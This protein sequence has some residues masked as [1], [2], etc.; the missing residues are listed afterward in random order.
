MTTTTDPSTTVSLA[1]ALAE[2]D[3]ARTVD[4]VADRLR[5]AGIT[6]LRRNTT[7]CPV[8]RYLSKRTGRR[9][10]AGAGQ[11]AT[12]GE[13]YAAYDMPYTVRSF[14]ERFDTEVGSYPDLV[15]TSPTTTVSELGMI[16]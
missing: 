1:E 8:A 12:N 11:V 5:G 14:I 15:D 13:W 9:V 16:M 4:G 6:G 2:L 3:A 7:H 10:R